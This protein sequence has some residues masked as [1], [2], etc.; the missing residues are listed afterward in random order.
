MRGDDPTGDKSVQ[1]GLNGQLIAPNPPV[2]DSPR[3]VHGGLVFEQEEDDFPGEGIRANCGIN[4]GFH[5]FPQPNLLTAN[6]AKGGTR[7]P[8]GS[9]TRNF[10]PESGSGTIAQPS[11]PEFLT[12]KTPR[13]SFAIESIESVESRGSRPRGVAPCGALHP[14]LHRA[15]PQG[16]QLTGCKAHIRPLRNDRIAESTLGTNHRM[17]LAGVLV[18]PFAGLVVESQ[19]PGLSFGWIT[20]RQVANHVPRHVL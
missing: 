16:R 8:R 7:T 19:Y 14:M 20:R 5:N 18:P 11:L 15:T 10:R 13:A 1:C 12:A 6:P 17:A 3:S 2:G 4:Q 9:H